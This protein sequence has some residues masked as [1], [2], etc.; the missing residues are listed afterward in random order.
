[1][2]KDIYGESEI[3]LMFMMRE[4]QDFLVSWVKCPAFFFMKIEVLPLP[5][6][7]LSREQKGESLYNGQESD[8]KSLK[9]AANE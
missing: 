3:S 8:L 2:C 7:S 9:T 5:P 4:T 6:P 1:M